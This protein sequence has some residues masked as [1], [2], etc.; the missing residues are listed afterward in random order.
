MISILMPIYNGIEYIDESVGSI[1]KQTYDHWELL[2]GINGHEKDSS[3]Y[4]IAKKYETTD[5]R[6]KVFD[7][8][9]IKGKSKTLNH[10]VK[11][12]K[13]EWVAL[14]D[15]DDIWLPT[16]LE[17]QI[18]YMEEYDVIGTKCKY[19]GDQSGS[20]NIP[21]G[22]ISNFNFIS[23]N[24]I[25]NSSS[26]TRKELCYWDETQ[27]M[28]GDYKLWLQLWKRKCKFYNVNSIEVLHRI[29][30]D[31]FFNYSNHK[32]DAQLRNQFR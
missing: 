22:N 10:M 19:F 18:E 12:C 11:H 32:Y 30:R 17:R 29:H 6:I 24:P 9:E 4:Q 28:A 3:V 13:Y 5:K 15:V 2:I 31:S 26:L 27:V 16:K 1:L 8:H 7:L 23:V 14:L 21:T 25:I 20:P